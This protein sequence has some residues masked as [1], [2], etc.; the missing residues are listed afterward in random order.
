MKKKLSLLKLS[1]NEL[2]V[3]KAGEDCRCGCMESGCPCSC[4]CSGSCKVGA[5]AGDMC[6]SGGGP[7][8]MQMMFIRV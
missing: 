2:N 8:E 6:G 1:E 7:A 4:D 5:R 3:V